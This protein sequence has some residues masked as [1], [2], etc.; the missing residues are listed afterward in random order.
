ML[1]DVYQ[2]SHYKK[3]ED[4]VECIEAI[5]SSMSLEAYR[6][7]LKGSLQKYTWRYEDKGTPKK[8]LLKAQVFLQKLI[9]TF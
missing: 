4:L 9:D 5:R 7:Y 8:D 3:G 2:P 1:D 6:G